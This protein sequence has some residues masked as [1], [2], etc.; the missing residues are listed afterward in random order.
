MGIVKT[1]LVLGGIGLA[2]NELNKQKTPTAQ[3]ANTLAAKPT[4]DTAAVIKAIQLNPDLLALVRGP[5]GPT[6]AT[7]A[8]GAV[9][10]AGEGRNYSGGLF[11]SALENN[12]L[13]CFTAITG[14]TLNTTDVANGLPSVQIVTLGS[15]GVAATSVKKAY[16]DPTKLYKVSYFV[17]CL[18]GTSGS[19]SIRLKCYDKAGAVTVKATGDPNSAYQNFTASNTFTQKTSYYGGIGAASTDAKKFHGDT[20]KA[21]LQ[22]L[23]NDLNKTMAFSKIIVEEVRLGDPVPYNLPYLPQWQMVYDPTTGD[24][25]IYNGTAVVWP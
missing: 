16:I 14:L 23:S 19:V 8:A 7:G 11:A 20:V 5:Q 2:I 17:K 21:E 25:G 10:S 6:G 22:V 1:G 18:V 4:I 15:Y 9:G 24:V 3:K 12:T 13:D